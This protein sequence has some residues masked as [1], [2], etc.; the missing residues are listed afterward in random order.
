M[1]EKAFIKH[2][3][4]VRVYRITQNNTIIWEKETILF[5]PHGFLLFGLSRSAG[6]LVKFG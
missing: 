2:E 6:T 3:R 5:N 4:K 1:K